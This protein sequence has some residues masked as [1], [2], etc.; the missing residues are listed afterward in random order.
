MKAA[1]GIGTVTLVIVCK[2][3]L[4]IRRAAEVD[5]TRIGAAGVDKKFSQRYNLP[6][7]V[8]GLWEGGDVNRAPSLG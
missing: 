4:F 7:K 1:P 5:P 2:S 8:W 6:Q 3:D